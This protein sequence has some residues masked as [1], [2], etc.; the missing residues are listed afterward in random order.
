VERRGA[1][2]PTE[3]PTEPSAWE[4]NIKKII[5]L[6]IL[7]KWMLAVRATSIRYLRIRVFSV[8]NCSLN[9]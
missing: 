2:D 1:I 6:L 4:E 3:S 8:N 9:V 7:K 5:R